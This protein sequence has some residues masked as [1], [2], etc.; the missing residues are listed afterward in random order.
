MTDQQPVVEKVVT[1]EPV[2]TPATEVPAEKSEEVRQLE[3]QKAALED[4]IQGLEGTVDSLKEDIVR[5]RQE[6]RETDGEQQ[7]IDKEALL[8]ELTPVLEERFQ[9]QLKP[10]L[11]ENQKLRKSILESNEKELK[12]KKAAR[13]AL[14]A[15]IASA[16]ASRA[17]AVETQPQE[18]VVLSAEEAKVAQELGLKNPR[19]M[20]DVE[21]L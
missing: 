12:A 19:Y 11:E 16:T 18:E 14:E 8:A 15:R 7:P 13:E 21:V 17:P 4:E 6:R 3:V 5:K 1:A 9:E 20:K 2:A 10:V